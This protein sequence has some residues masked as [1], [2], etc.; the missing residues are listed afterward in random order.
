MT[1]TPL[2]AARMKSIPFSGIRKVFEECTRLENQGRDLV[3]LEV[4]R[5]DFDTPAPIK[6]AGIEAIEEGHVHHTSN[7]GIPQLRRTIAKKYE[8]ENDVT[9]NPDEEVIVTA[10]GTEAYLITI[11]ALVD[12]GDE[13]LIPDPSW[14]YKPAINMAGGTPVRYDLDPTTGFTPDDEDVAA[15]ISDRTKMVVLNSPQNPTGGVVDESTLERLADLVIEHD[16]YLISD[17]IYEKILFDDRTHHSPSSIP[18]LFNRTVIINGC[19]KAH[20]MTGWRLGYLCAPQQLINPIIR[21]R[22]YTTTCAS[23]IA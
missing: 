10:G 8:T 17:E 13:V 7:Y 4:G 20:S 19:S 2:E 14:T 15:T 22:Q 9:Y 18:E 12:P 16:C 5:P 6:Q 23:S 3:H 1:S 21:I 11:L